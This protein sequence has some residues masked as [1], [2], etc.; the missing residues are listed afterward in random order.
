MRFW[1][2]NQ[3]KT[4]KQELRGGYMWC[5]KLKANEVPN[6]FYE[7][8]RQVQPG[9]IVFSYAKGEIRALGTAITPCVSSD[10]PESFGKTGDAVVGTKSVTELCRHAVDEA[11]K[12]AGVSWKNI[13]A[14][15][16]AP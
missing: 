13:E 16:A 10:K 11:F 2:V 12:D 15:A 6:V 14:I 5:P 7:Y 8:M 4:H 9:D 1:W 3:N